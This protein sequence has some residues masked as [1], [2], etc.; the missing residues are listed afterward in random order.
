MT[1]RSR[2]VV[3]AWVSL[4]IVGCWFALTSS[5]IRTEFSL[6]LP[7]GDSITQ[8]LLVDHIHHGSTSRIIL[9]ALTG[10]HPDLLASASK[11]LAERLRESQDFSSIQNGDL[12]ELQD[13]ADLLFHYRYLLS[14]QISF[15]RFQEPALR[16]ALS[17]RIRNLGSVF[18]P[19]LNNQTTRDPTGEVLEILRVWTPPNSLT[20]HN[21]IWFSSDEQAALLAV[22]TKASGFD[23]D[24]QEL[25]QQQLRATMS[26]ITTRLG[27]DTP[28]KILMT[29]P[30]IFAV[31]SRAQIKMEA[32]WLTMLAGGMMLMFLFLNYRSLRLIALILVPLA[33]GLLLS[34]LVVNWTFG[35]IHGLTLAFGT[36]LIGVA[37]DYP[38]HVISHLSPQHSPVHTIGELWPIIGLG[39][40]TTALGYCA[41][42]F[43]GFPGLIQLGLFA[44]IGLLS[45]ALTTKLVL[46]HMIPAGTEVSPVGQE[47]L[48]R[49]GRLP[50]L[51]GIIPVIFLVSGGYLLWSPHAFWEQDITRLSPLSAEVKS[52]DARL[53]DKIGAPAVR[54]LMVIIEPTQEAVLQTSEKLI[55][56]LEEEKRRD[57]MTGYEMAGQFLPSR[58][59]QENRQSLLPSASSLRTRINTVQKDFPFKSGIFEPFIQ[60]ITKAKFQKVV[61][62]QTL[63]KTAYG[64]KLQSLLFPYDGQWAGIIH[65]HNVKNRDRLRT[66]SRNIEGTRLFY[67][68]LKGEAE[69][70]LVDYRD[71]VIKFLSFGAIAIIL[72][73]A[74]RLRSWVLLL[75]IITT[76]SVSIITV[77]AI[78]HFLHEQISLFHLSALLLVIGIGLDYALFLHHSHKYPEFRSRTVWAVLICSTTT[79]MA[80]GLL[81]ISQTPVLHSIGLTASLGA[82]CC[83]IF[84]ALSSQ[85][86]MRQGTS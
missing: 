54:D 82:L 35:Y 33:S 32:Q 34:I 49:L 28:L 75:G 3:L 14:P 61:T 58:K 78:L 57:T 79:I 2:T 15:S 5:Q 26:D 31:A 68:D 71:E 66:L 69:Q 62:L 7:T 64:I 44:I 84:S 67:L 85:M 60:D 86:V 41:M 8:Q 21:G 51:W 11:M 45:S 81:A 42:V 30:T 29:G 74:V 76:V 36:T 73:L 80:F 12:L 38:V 16:T 40:I 13:D 46:P 83:L 27:R 50:S 77:L 20:R 17:H 52:Y 72:V 22:Q 59:T 4:F 23:L 9:I 70:L 48:S 47:Y 18:S 25:I 55:P 37:I 63:D 10:A 1:V 6:L 24:A 53:R 65:F 43:S 19:F 39:A 56:L